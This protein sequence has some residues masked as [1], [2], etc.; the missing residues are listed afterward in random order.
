[1]AKKTTTTKSKPS[2]TEVVEETK[3]VATE[4]R[5]TNMSEESIVELDMNL[6]DYDDFEPLPAGEYPA[7]VTL[8]EMRTSDKGNDY[9]YLTFQVHPDDYPA[10]YP[11]ENAPE[12]TNL[13]Y[14]RVQKPDPRNRRSITNVKN[15][16]RALG[17]DIKVS[18]IN[19]GEWE[20]KKAKL[21]L[22]KDNFNGMPNNSIVSIEALD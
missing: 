8:S 11:V 12:G 10:D 17:C 6:A 1:M 22:K 16:M 14:A 19:P 20:G 21:V 3:P 15:L 4:K 7:T 5:N 9:Y 18:V 2:T 13:V